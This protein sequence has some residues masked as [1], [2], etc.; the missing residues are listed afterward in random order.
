MQEIERKFLVTSEAF[1]KNATRHFFILQGFLNTDPQRTVRVR[2]SDGQG[3]LTVKGL[4]DAKGIERFEW[5]KEIS[6][7]D[8]QALLKLCEPGRIEKERFCVPF[9]NH[10]FEVDVFL[11]E[12]KGLIIAEIELQKTDESFDKP[13]WLGLEVTGDARYYN[14]QLA[15]NPFTKW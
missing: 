3:V 11:G 4:S 14:S 15:K 10:L 12:N 9:S 2:L 5:E 1:K 6:E 8:A 7:T 13:D